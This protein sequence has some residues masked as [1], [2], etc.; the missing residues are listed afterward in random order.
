MF[1]HAME[2]MDFQISTKLGT[3]LDALWQEVID[4]RDTRLKDMQPAEKRDK[5]H[6][7]FSKNIVKKFF[8]VVW[9]HAGLWV[10]EMEFKKDFQSCFATC[11]F[12]GDWGA[13]QIQNVMSGGL[14]PTDQRTS[15]KTAEEMLKIVKAFDPKTGGIKT[16]VRNKMRELVHC[17]MYF[18]FAE[19][20]CT[21][22]YFPKGTP[23]EY[24]TAREIT[25]IM[26]HEIGHSL[27]LLDHAADTYVHVGKFESLLNGF[28]RFGKPE[29]HAKFIEEIASEAM[30]AKIPEAEQLKAVA[31]KMKEDF[32][33]LND[34]NSDKAR[35]YA[36]PMFAMAGTLAKGMWYGLKNFFF[37]PFYNKYMDDAQ[38]KKYSDVLTSERDMS[39]A[40]RA[41]DE[42][43]TRHGYGSDV[44]TG[45]A[46]TAESSKYM[47][48][49]KEAIMAMVKAGRF[50]TQLSLI[51]KLKLASVIPRYA[52][53]RMYH[54]Y[55]NGPDRFKE[56][57]KISVAGLKANGANPDFIAKYVKDI[58]T[59][60]ESIKN[61]DEREGFI[62]KSMV[63]YKILLSYLSVTSWVDI[64][65][66]GRLVPEIE[67]LLSQL[68]DLSN[69]LLTF[70]G[71]KL[72]QLAN[73]R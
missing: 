19:A 16:G 72:N 38:Y 26:L 15:I 46:K 7:Y 67:K 1:N 44:V 20:F 47:G 45:L 14:D 39:W 68:D 51:N 29:E 25:A 71:E 54:L 64:I 53:W 73:R 12:V 58:E 57:V 70:Y 6:D 21:V 56:I 10:D 34:P 3:N 13:D 59:M 9:K 52:G 50:E 8:D 61:Y 43:A 37:N 31:V 28:K 30:S 63:R 4:Y 41:A 24:M 60:L 2:A 40:E 62:A 5:L 48:Y 36:S 33:K 42:Y 65:V 17:K 22:D 55:P 49:S 27:S 35:V 23:V 32:S 18:D 66:H 11:I 69:N